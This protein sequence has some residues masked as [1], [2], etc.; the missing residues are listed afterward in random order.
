M[1]SWN[2]VTAGLLQWLLAEPKPGAEC[3]RTGPDE[4]GHAEEPRGTIPA[5]KHR[6][7]GHQGLAMKTPAGGQGGVGALSSY[8][9]E[10][11]RNLVA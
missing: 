2:K 11:R 1:R 5:H 8:V 7:A 4:P 10:H 6:S 3:S 9:H